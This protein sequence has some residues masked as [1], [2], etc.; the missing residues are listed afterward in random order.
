MKTRRSSSR[1]RSFREASTPGKISGSNDFI[2]ATDQTAIDDRSIKRV[3]LSP[4]LVS[5]FKR[6]Q[7]PQC[8]EEYDCN[9]NDDEVEILHT[10]PSPQSIE[11]PPNYIKEETP[12]KFRSLESSNKNEAKNSGDFNAAIESEPIPT[13]PHHGTIESSPAQMTLPISSF[14]H[15]TS[16][17]LQSL[18]E[19]SHAVLWD[20]RWRVGGSRQ[21]RLFQWEQ[22]DDLNALYKLSRRYTQLSQLPKQRKQFRNTHTS[23]DH[24]E[25]KENI[26][27]SGGDSNSDSDDNF[28]EL[29]EIVVEDEPDDRCLETYS[30][31]YFRKGPWFR[32]D[33]I[34][35]SYYVPKTCQLTETSADNTQNSA[36]MEK[37]NITP[38][39]KKPVSPSKFFRRQS[40]TD[41]QNVNSN[42][43]V[44]RSS[45][46]F[47]KPSSASEDDYIDHE[48]V[49]LQMEA[50]LLLLGDI[51]RL[52]RMGL[53]RS[54]LSEGEC[55]RTVGKR[56]EKYDYVAASLLRQD[57]QRTVLAKIG[58]GQKQKKPTASNPTRITPNS[59]STKKPLSE[60]QQQPLE[61]LIWKQMHQQQTI[62]NCFKN[63]KN[64]TVLPVI[65]HVHDILVQK[66]ASA[67][68]LKASKVEYIPSPIFRSA[69]RRV[70]N[71]LLD[72][73]SKSEITS[74][75]MC[76]RL[77]E[78]PV[79]TLR[80]ASRL[81]L[82]ATSGPGD[83]RNSG[84]NAWRSL[85][86]S[87]TK[88]LRKMPL[89]TNLVAPPGSSWNT[90]SYPGKDW[91]LRVI[92]CH[93]MNAFKPMT[94]NGLYHD[95]I[96]VTDES[97]AEKDGSED[98]FGFQK[99]EINNTAM[100]LNQDDIH[101]FSSAQAF[102]QW[103]IG[104]E[105]REN[106]DFLLEMN[107][108]ILYN[109]RKQ[110]RETK[111]N[112][113]DQND[114][115][116]KEVEH[117]G[118]D[119]NADQSSLEDDG[120][121]MADTKVD[122][123][124]LLTIMGRAKIIRGLLA[125]QIND[126]KSIIS[127]IE[128]D[129]SM[130]LGIPFGDR[131]LSAL[132]VSTATESVENSHLENECERILGVIGIMLL[133]ILEIRNFSLK[134]TDVTR[135]VK[136]PWLRHMYWEGCMSYVLW[137]IIPIFERRGYY[138]FAINALEVLL[139]GRRLP[140]ANN[141]IIPDSFNDG[142]EN[143]QSEFPHPY[144][145]L[146]SRR[147]RGKALD[148]LIIDHTHFAR[149]NQNA[150]CLTKPEKTPARSKK[151][152]SPKSNVNE[153][154]KLLT[155]PLI[156]TSVVSGQIS[157]SSIRTLARRLKCPL[158]CTLEGLRSFEASELG[159]RLSN[160]GD[161]QQDLTK[162]NDWSPVT[163][164][165][166][167][168]A[169]GNDRDSMAGR[170]SFV[171][172]EGDDHA[173]RMGSLNVEELAEEYYHQGRLPICDE[174]PS[175]GGWIGYHD[176]GGKIRILFRIL[177]ST[178]LCMDWDCTADSI[179]STSE[180]LTIHLTP[181]QGA[182]FDLHVGAEHVDSEIG[183]RGI[184]TRRK[185]R[186]D[187]FLEKLSSLDGE[188]L[189]NFVYSCIDKRLQYTNSLN[190]PDLML[191]SDLQQVRTL[192]M[193][194]VGFGGK[195]LASIFRCFFFDYRHY[196]GGLP[197]LLL[198]RA[199]YTSSPDRES[200]SSDGIVK[201]LV[202]LGEWVGEAF[203]SEHQE[204]IKA[205]QVSRI[206]MDTDSDFLGCSKVGDSGGRATN[207]FQRSGRSRN[208]KDDSSKDE[209]PKI[210]Y[211]IS[212]RL[213]LSHGSQQIR[214]ECMFVEVKSQNDRL[215]SRQEDWLNILD[216]HGNA[217]VCK[218]EKAPKSKK[219]YRR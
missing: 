124:D 152:K 150:G 217:R 145:P 72:L 30:R 67:I 27:Y 153:M 87:H 110:A 178:V 18:A 160:G 210:P 193:L 33:N 151:K 130:L 60:H 34:Y 17:Y 45:S 92:S 127:K 209:K 186:I 49:D 8:S 80:R 201:E 173:V 100:P 35:K 148:R 175:K 144:Q 218:F 44:C 42:T 50:V 76:L 38:S 168:N 98:K 196:T 121:P 58:G 73:T 164:T 6:R 183:C 106:C 47:Q 117:D 36:D 103:E 213:R 191:E 208:S 165:A 132:I 157:F 109:E 19:I 51:K 156:K 199:L 113:D 195:M 26:E 134:Q 2:I 119:R 22:G 107:E 62:F 123:L 40:S 189:S 200:V 180:A 32:L 28:E 39:M 163:D 126:G 129:I 125:L 137:D 74:T 71:T 204:A 141:N 139:F 112:D 65:K 68:I 149:K 182:P 9:D 171:G 154:V 94:V 190:R 104:V 102:H 181:Y 66:W 188:D 12:K 198:V 13:P 194:A 96:T 91:R 20:A 59:S 55:G 108:L 177:S 63:R 185:S 97:V 159:H 142:D 14:S 211:K 3:S 205:K 176:E 43:N 7:A 133:H 162:Y 78:A 215:D 46:T 89:R 81:Y 90:V 203:S 216:L 167:A 41:H 122:F 169:M 48:F 219:R 136:R 128:Q 120:N 31:L 184:Y 16:A 10:N 116:S 95:N 86:D 115:N 93:F 138:K 143:N 101:V 82:C 69:T 79:R 64:S 114:I 4:P 61:N 11:A 75:I 24:E 147:A 118:L 56:R 172:L 197:D 85:P 88:D 207:R 131:S 206:F 15:R 158:S 174:S 135:M 192:S 52:F 111:F 140:R 166:V 179:L 83:M 214:V 161:Q 155:E 99:S 212:E 53:I 70:Y 1:K 105:L 5:A 170:C 23:S 21:D 77:R 146:I 202:D 54:F 25:E 57:E 29:E 84:T 37:E 187:N